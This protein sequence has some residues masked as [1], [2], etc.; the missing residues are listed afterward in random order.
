M[1]NALHK[2]G[3]STGL[4]TTARESYTARQPFP[5]IHIRE[6][7]L[8]SAI[9]SLPP[10]LNRPDLI[11]F[12]STYVPIHALLAHQ[13]SRLG[14]PY[15]IVPRGGMTYGA[16]RVKRLKKQI[17]NLLFFKRFVNGAIA[18]HCLTPRE[19]T[20]AQNWGRPVFVEGNGINLPPPD[21]LAQPGADRRLQLVFIGRFDI[22]HKGLDLLIRA[23]ALAKQA[24]YTAQAQ[25]HLYGPDI[26][27]SKTVM[28]DMIK[29]FDLQPIVKIH[30]P[31]YN[32]QK[33]QVL[34]HTDLFLHTSRFEGHPMAVLEA[35]AYGIPCLLTVGTNFSTEV[36]KAGAGWEADINA[37]SIAAAMRQ[38][39]HDRPYLTQMGTMAR[40]LA[41]TKYSWERV[42]QR[43]LEHYLEILQP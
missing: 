9:A 28:A 35:L 4:L 11:V 40:K 13:A 21:Q 24:L 41:E 32:S 26:K 3:V 1:V 12:H 31:V 43:L 23:C 29:D 30:G 2:L 37:K 7:P 36:A 42:G 22:H 25:V 8:R 27:G 39:L 33:K 20:E 16:Q 34:R 6:L 10:P 18:I 5:I 14:I 15:L 17:G 38:A 19:A